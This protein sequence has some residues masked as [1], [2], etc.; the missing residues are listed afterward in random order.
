MVEFERLEQ[1]HISLDEHNANVNM[2][3]NAVHLKWGPEYVVVTGDGLEVDNSSGIQGTCTTHRTTTN[4]DLVQL[5]SCISHWLL[6]IT[7]I[8]KF[9]CVPTRKFY[10][11]RRD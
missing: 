4:I 1:T 5:L 2:V 3:T 10:A 9:W 6:F 8:G 11:I 7:C